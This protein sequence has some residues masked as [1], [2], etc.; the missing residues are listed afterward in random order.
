MPSKLYEGFNL[1]SF[2]RNFL[3]LKLKKY[4][5]IKMIKKVIYP[6]KFLQNLILSNLHY[7]PF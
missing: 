3:A 1:Y 7:R 4:H 5:R 2:H 6:E